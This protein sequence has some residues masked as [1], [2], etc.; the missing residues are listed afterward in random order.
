MYKYYLDLL[1]YDYPS[2]IDKY[3]EVPSLVRLKNVSYFCGMNKASKNIYNFLED[4]SRFDHSLSVSLL[5]WKLTHN[6]IYTLSALFHDVSTPA[7]SHVIDYMNKDY[8]LCESTEEYTFDILKN[9][10]ML[11]CLLK[12]DNIKLDDIANY[13]KYSIVDNNRPK[14]CADRVDGII[15][16]GLLWGKTLNKE[17]IKVIVDSLTIYYNE[18]NEEEIGFNNKKVLDIV[19]KSNN[20]INELT[21]SKEDYYMMQLLADI[22]KY[23]IDNNIIKYEELYYLD[24]DDIY[25]RL[26]TSNDKYLLDKIYLFENIKEIPDIAIPNIKIKSINPLVKGKRLL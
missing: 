26:K 4:V 19:I 9:D 5:T 17:D 24:E 18:D 16:N 11:E 12:E 13:K 6:K 10:K 8:I 22:T 23:A 15:L 7:F 2:F 25:N 21:H 14:L 20:I 3:L 1:K